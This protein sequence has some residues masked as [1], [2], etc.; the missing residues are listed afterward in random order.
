MCEKSRSIREREDVSSLVRVFR[1]ALPLRKH[2]AYYA[3]NKQ[4]YKVEYDDSHN[5]RSRQSIKLPR[6]VL[7]DGDGRGLGHN[8]TPRRPEWVRW[9]HIDRTFFKLQRKNWKNFS[10][11]QAI[12]ALQQNKL[13]KIPTF[14]VNIFRFSGEIT[15]NGSG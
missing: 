13:S 4:R 7:L 1:P 14:G 3:P 2:G 12:T 8:S 15:K 10:A 6:L 11:I 9:R 5:E